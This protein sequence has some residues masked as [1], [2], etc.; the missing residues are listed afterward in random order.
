MTDPNIEKADPFIGTWK[1]APDACA[2]EHGEVPTD[3]IC[4]I[5]TD[6]DQYLIR[7]RLE[8]EAGEVVRE[9]TVFTYP[10]GI[11]REMP[12]DATVPGNRFSLTRMDLQTL[13]EQLLTNDA[14][15]R[16][17]R[18]VVSDDENMLS[19]TETNTTPDGDK[20]TN[21]TVYARVV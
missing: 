3:G 19:V 18:R 12:E 8:N 13:D 20:Y 14:L 17:T 9:T 21:K 1:L 7:V 10:D 2:Y 11:A 15:V 6:V 4:E 5:R 16:F